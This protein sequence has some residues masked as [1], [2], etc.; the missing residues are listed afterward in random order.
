MTLKEYRAYIVI[1]LVK[2][3][4]VV[5]AELD[6]PEVDFL[7]A[8]EVHWRGDPVLIDFHLHVAVK[9]NSVKVDILFELAFLELVEDNFAVVSYLL[10]EPKDQVICSLY[11]FLFTAFGRHQLV[12]L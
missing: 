8:D 12:H 2:C 9:V 4:R 1:F 3:E 5:T 10:L 11:V 7:P 6:V